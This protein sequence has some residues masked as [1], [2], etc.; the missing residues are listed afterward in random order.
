MKTV[1]QWLDAA[2][3]DEVVYHYLLGSPP[4]YWEV[5]GA[6]VGIV[7]SFAR[8]ERAVREFISG[9]LALQAVGTHEE[10]FFG[11][12]T[13]REN[14]RGIE[15]D[16]IH[17]DEISGERVERY[18]WMMSDREELAG[19]LIADTE[20]DKE[21]IAELLASILEEATF[22]GFSEDRFRERRHELEQDLEKSIKQIDAGEVYTMEEVEEHL[23]LPPRKKD[24]AKQEL[25]A[26]VYR[27]QHELDSYCRDCELNEIRG[28]LSQNA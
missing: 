26:S 6:E 14:S 17:I 27:A 18:D 2:D 9:F 11:Y 15:V 13:Y 21:N 24:P 3:I 19:Y 4:A 1:Q 25:R 10:M 16:L 23:G 8:I 28:Q 20:F 22:L 12:P 7:E 5:K